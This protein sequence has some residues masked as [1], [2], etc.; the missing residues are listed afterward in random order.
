M[1]PT[2]TLEPI[3]PTMQLE[4]AITPI[5]A[6]IKIRKKRAPKHDFKDG[7]G[8]VFAHR[9]DNG[10]GWVADTARVTDSV[11][12]GPRA[13]VYQ[14][15]T[16][17]DDCRLE[18]TASVYGHATVSGKA[19]VKNARVFGVATVQDS[20]K[21]KD[22]CAVS[23]N[24]FVGGG[25]ELHVGFRVIE[26]A[27]VFNS[28]L[29]GYGVISGHAHIVRSNFRTRELEATGNVT[30]I[31]ATIVG[32]ARLTQYANMLHSIIELNEVDNGEVWL[33]DF[34]IISSNT[35]ITVP[36][37]IKNHASLAHTT[38]NT[39]HYNND[40]RGRDRLII[41]DNM[42]I[43]NRS[44]NSY[45]TFESFLVT[46]APPPPPPPQVPGFPP[47]VLPNGTQPVQRAPVIVAPINRRI[48]NPESALS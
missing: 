46:G 32:R 43:S 22:N 4:P 24:A 47:R 28:M 15:A 42:T 30:A 10:K 33:R 25:S 36:V 14:Y 12:V 16:I 9:H 48:M 2:A 34:A 6:P 8:K 27:H 17:R 35:R 11:Y 26:H 18:G 21:I 1:E 29:R 44:F 37:E 23:G 13:Q 5:P 39:N 31:N 38:L 45:V 40:W 41:R 19:L 3:K 7:V 20:A